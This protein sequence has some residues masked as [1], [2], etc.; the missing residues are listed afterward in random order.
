MSLEERDQDRGD[1]LGAGGRATHRHIKVSFRY[2]GVGFYELN[3]FKVVSGLGEA[4][5]G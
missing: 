2:M 3:G 1:C 4:T 5:V